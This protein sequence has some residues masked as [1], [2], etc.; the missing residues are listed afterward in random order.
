MRRDTVQVASGGSV[1]LRFIA[2]KPTSLYSCPWRLITRIIRQP[3]R[4]APA[5]YVFRLLLVDLLLTNRSQAT[6]NGT[7]RPVLL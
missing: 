3:W 6:S 2:G 4:V 5:L 1:R 7:W